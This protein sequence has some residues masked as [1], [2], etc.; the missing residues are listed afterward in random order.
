MTTRPRK[1]FRILLPSLFLLAV[2]SWFVADACLLDRATLAFG[3]STLPPD[4]L[5]GLPEPR[6]FTSPDSYVWLSHVRDMLLSGDWRIRH[7]HMDNAPYGRPMHW[8]HLLIWEMAAHVRL[9]QRFR[10]GMFLS[11]AVEI[12]GRCAMPLFGILFIVPLYCAFVRRLGFLPAAFFAVFLMVSPLFLPTFTPLAPDHHVFQFCFSLVVVVA[13]SFG[14]WGLVSSAGGQTGTTDAPVRPFW[15]RPLSPPSYPSARRWFLLAGAAHACLLWVGASVWL[16]VHTALCLAALAALVS[17]DPGCRPAPRLWLSFLATSLPLSIAFYL[18]EYAPCFP[19]MRLEVNHP[20]YWLFLLGTVLVLHSAA[21]SIAICPPVQPSQKTREKPSRKPSLL[22]FLL[23]TARSPRILVPFVLGLLLA[24]LLP[25]A[26]LFGPASWHALHDPFLKRLHARCIVEFQPWLPIVLKSPSALFLSLRFF[27]IFLFAVP[28]LAFSPFPRIDSGTRRILRPHAVLLL[29]FLALTL[30]Q[31]RWST[32]LFALLVLPSLLV[33]FL[34][35]GIL[36]GQ[37]G[38]CSPWPRRIAGALL[39]LFALDTAWG[40][41]RDTRELL[42]S[43]RYKTPVGGWM[44]CD[45][46]KRASLRLAAAS[47]GQSWIFAGNPSDAPAF[48]W[49]GGIPSIAS[50]YWE[51]ADGWH[52]EAS[53]LSAPPDAISSDLLAE[54]HARGLSHVLV[55][56]NSHDPCI[57]HYLASGAYDPAFAVRHTLHGVLARHAGSVHPVPVPPPFVMDSDLTDTLSRTNYYLA[58]RVG[59]DTVFPNHLDWSA[60]ALPAAPS[61]ESPVVVPNP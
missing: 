16:V 30:F 17:P 12:A 11:P 31:V 47:S 59:P 43:L 55:A 15:V 39:V 22:N 3:R 28:L 14:G 38:H 9:L 5:S 46:V 53:L 58:L 41:V 8:S 26:L 54:A 29:A 7:T 27:L 33:L 56:P 36:P 49:F 6:F 25:I 40:A 57:A 52:A 37:Y 50:Y 61:P 20:L 1:L 51:N 23:A 45:Q 34:P 32:F 24:S 35:F 19:G 4:T 42:L 60:F 48:Y 2:L 13:L 44:D 18:L 10:P 21:S